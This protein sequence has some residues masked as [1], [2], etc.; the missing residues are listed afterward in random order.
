MNIKWLLLFL[1]SG[2]I[3]AQNDSYNETEIS[4]TPLVD[5]TLLI[6]ST[7]TA[8]PLAI[9]IAGSG[10]TDRN[11]NQNMM[12]SNA[13]KHLAEGLYKQG[14]ATFRYD[15]RIVAQLKNRT[16]QEE[17]IRF[18]DFVADAEK[19]LDYFQDDTRFSKIHVIGHSQGSLVGMLAAK[20]RADGFISLAGAGQE[21]DD[22]IIDQLQMQSPGLVDN[23]RTAFDDL[24]VNGVAQ[25]YSP[26][27][28]S[29]FRPQIQPFLLSWM[30]YDPA[31]ILSELDM[32]ILIVNGT[33]DLQVLESEA[34]LL[35]ES[36][37]E[38]SLVL[39]E[40]MNHV[41]KEITG[42]RLENSKS[43]NEPQRP[44]MPELITLLSEFIKK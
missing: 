4:I 23:A 42:D 7:E 17:G 15:K 28:A 22:V 30:Q 27:L 20:D 21:I 19:V 5:G 34:A 13:Y 38:A 6:P 43:Y 16:I 3:V 26:Y 14:V 32:P 12:K 40:N 44:V 1:I 18:E 9:I 41:L 37:S 36:V 2:Y 10:P 8:P 24:R 31:A 11:G 39:I 29:I 25:N 33:K 35:K